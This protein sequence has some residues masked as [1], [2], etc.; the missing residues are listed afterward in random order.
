MT[1]AVFI[2]TFCRNPE[3][4]YGSLLVFQTLRVGFP[5]ARV[6]V[7]DN[8]SIPEVREAIR[9]GAERVGAEFRQ[10]HNAVAHY[11]WLRQCIASAGDGPAAIVDPDMAF[12]GAVE[13]PAGD[14]LVAG[15]L[16]PTFADAVTNTITLGRLHTSLWL[17]PSASRLLAAADSL[18][19]R[20]RGI[21]AGAKEFDAFRPIAFPAHGVMYRLDTGA[22]LYQAFP[23]SCRAFTP[24]ELDRYDH[25]IAGCHLDRVTAA[26]EPGTASALAGTHDAAQHDVASIRGCWRQQEA[27]YQALAVRGTPHLCDEGRLA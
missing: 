21:E 9:A 8:A 1:P 22:A 16:L 10:H 7:T 2:L 18:E 17:I 24:A 14:Y 23:R 5:D 11:Q 13:Y 3:S 26:L 27:V 6:V 15:R 25:L 12:W 4:L 20:F 19:T